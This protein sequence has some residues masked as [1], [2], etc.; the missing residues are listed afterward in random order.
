MRVPSIN[1]VSVLCPCIFSAGWKRTEHKKRES[2]DERHCPIPRGS[3]G[4]LLA[5]DMI[6]GWAVGA[7]TLFFSVSLV[8][9]ASLLLSISALE[10]LFKNLCSTRFLFIQSSKSSFYIYPSFAHSVPY[11]RV[12]S[13]AIQH[14]VRYHQSSSYQCLKWCFLRQHTCL[15]EHLWTFPFI[16]FKEVSKEDVYDLKCSELKSWRSGPICL[17]IKYRSLLLFISWIF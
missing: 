9:L 11:P 10:P 7:D 14:W 17:N 2:P 1:R 15:I 6:E 16:F 4:D 12:T 8:R 5:I 3:S 13:S